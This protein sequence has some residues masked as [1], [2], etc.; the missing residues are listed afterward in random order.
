MDSIWKA[1]ALGIALL[2]PMTAFGEEEATE[3]QIREI[4]LDIRTLELIHRLDLEKDPRQLVDPRD[5]M[6]R[7]R[8]EHQKVNKKASL[9]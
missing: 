7:L 8:T 6:D 9:N 3:K 1:L 4:Q 2:F 5:Q